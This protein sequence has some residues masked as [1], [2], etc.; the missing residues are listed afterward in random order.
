MKNIIKKRYLIFIGSTTYISLVTTYAYSIDNILIQVLLQI[1]EW[2][3]LPVPFIS[4]FLCLLDISYI[5]DSYIGKA[6]ENELVA[7]LGAAVMRSDGVVS[8]KERNVFLSYISN[9]Y[10]DKKREKEIVRI[11]DIKL[12]KPVQIGD[13]CI[14][15]NEYVHYNR[16]FSICRAMF[17]IA[18]VEN[19]ICSQ[20]KHLL[21][22]TMRLLKL[23]KKDKEH[24]WAE[25]GFNQRIEEKRDDNKF[26]GYLRIMEL[27]V[28]AT[29]A[30]IK[31]KYKELCFEHHPDRY[32]NCDEMTKNFHNN[33]MKSINEAYN[34]L[35]KN[36]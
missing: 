17:R 32:E 34:I 14:E 18:L 16:R 20:E 31:K 26:I 15:S 13:I 8:H 33:K 24:L 28:N 3:L 22:K 10:N 29:Q 27:G 19:G 1:I 2:A 35:L 4:I 21:E 9:K 23:S 11:L 25:F 36:Y 7:T 12:K 30:D 5:I 6:K